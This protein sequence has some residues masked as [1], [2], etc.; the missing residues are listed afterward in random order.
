VQQ[1]PYASRA[2]IDT[3][4][5]RPASTA[6]QPSASKLRMRVRDLRHRFLGEPA[7]HSFQRTLVQ[8]I[9]G[10]AAECPVNWGWRPSGGVSPTGLARGVATLFGMSVRAFGLDGGILRRPLEWSGLAALHDFR[11]TRQWLDRDL[12]DFA[13]DL[14]RSADL[15]Q[16]DLFESAALDRVLD[17]HF[18]GRQDHHTTVTF[19]LDLG[20][21]WRN[22]SR[23]TNS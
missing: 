2:L 18:S 11:E 14:L 6:G 15:R 12:R 19:A 21:A 17:A 20:L 5:Q 23:A 13:N 3:L 8:R 22:F 7:D 4:A 9:G 1:S 10:F 16:A